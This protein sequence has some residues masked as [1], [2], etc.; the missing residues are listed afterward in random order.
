[1]YCCLGSS[2]QEGKTPLELYACPKPGHVFPTSHF[3]F[4]SEKVFHFED[5][6]GTVD[7]HY[8]FIKTYT[9]FKLES[10]DL[11]VCEVFCVFIVCLYVCEC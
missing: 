6:G 3:V 7:H 8:L 11:C 4:V 5:I 10:W 9:T 2:C 1:M